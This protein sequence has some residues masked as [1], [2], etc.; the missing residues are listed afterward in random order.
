L[1]DALKTIIRNNKSTYYNTVKSIKDTPITVTPELPAIFIG[2]GNK[3]RQQ[4]FP[5]ADM[6]KVYFEVAILTQL[7]GK[8]TSLNY[9]LSITEGVK[10]VLQSNHQMGGKAEWSNITSIEYEPKAF[11]N[12]FVYMTTINLECQTREYL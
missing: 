8:E 6:S 10:D 3:L 12:E 9:N 7:F 4:N 5:Q 2:A 11:G 1:Q